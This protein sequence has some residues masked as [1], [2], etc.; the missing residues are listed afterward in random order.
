G[1]PREADE[2]TP[3]YA[4]AIGYLK[5]GQ[6]A[7]GDNPSMFSY[8]LVADTYM[9]W[10]QTEDMLLGQQVDRPKARE[11]I[12]A[13]LA[14]VTESDNYNAAAYAARGLNLAWLDRADEARTNLAQ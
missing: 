13:N 12:E 8:W 4:L 7:E 2:T 3:L 14:K 1:K 5:M 10:L 6:A 9:E 11:E